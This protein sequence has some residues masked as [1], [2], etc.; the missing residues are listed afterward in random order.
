MVCHGLMKEI[1]TDRL[2]KFI[3]IAH[4]DDGTLKKIAYILP[5][6]LTHSFKDEIITISH[7]SSLF[8][9][10]EC[11]LPKPNVAEFTLG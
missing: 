11:C 7:R 3:K 9:S 2:A 6:Q 5:R 1:C 10:T 4:L 8:K